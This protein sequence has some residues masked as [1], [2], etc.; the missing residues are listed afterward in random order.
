M[1]K[2]WSLVI[3]IILTLSLVAGCEKVPDQS[4]VEYEGIDA[5]PIEFGQLVAVTTMVEYPGWSQL[6]FRADDGT[7]RMVRYH[8]IRDVIL[9]DVKTLNRTV[10]EGM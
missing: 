1:S 6:W 3:C 2:T 4:A 5:V 7:V 8:F 10:P 9:A